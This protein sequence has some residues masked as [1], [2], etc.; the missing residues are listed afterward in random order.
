[1]KKILLTLLAASL[2]F[3]SSMHGQTLEYKFVKRAN[4]RIGANYNFQNGS[5][6]DSLFRSNK[7]SLQGNIFLGYRFDPNGSSANYFGL[8]GAVSSIT[9]ASLYQMRADQAL[10]LPSTYTI[11]KA[12]V[13]EIEGGFI[14]GDWFR[15]SAGPGVM[16][17]P[18]TGNNSI[19]YKYFSGTTGVS[20]NLGKLKFNMN[21]SSLFG[22]DLKKN[23]WRAGVGL[24][25]SFDFLNAR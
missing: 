22:G 14:F 1:M 7:G 18:T 17:V 15:I 21:A 13:M 23:V 6:F 20:F 12:S 5:S 16:R 3:S 24:G 19:K 8:F 9:P 2:V 25:F 4:L 11:E 10:I